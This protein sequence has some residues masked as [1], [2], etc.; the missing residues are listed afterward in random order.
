[1]TEASRTAITTILFTDLVSSTELLQ[2]VGDERAQRI[3]ERHHELLRDAIAAAGGEELQWMGDG[4]MAAFAS[5]ADAVRCAVVMQRAASRGTAGERL[6]IRI[7]L[8]TAET[9]RQDSGSGHFGTPVVVA[10]RLCDV[11]GPGQILCSSV[12]AGLLQGRQ[13]FRFRDVGQRELKGI[14]AP[15]AVCEALYELEHG[16]GVPGRTPFVGRREELERLGQRL[17]VA[18]SGQGGLAMLVGEPGIG[19]TRLLEELAAT[20]RE[21]DTRVLW[22]RCYEGEWAPP[23]GPFAEAIA[24][25]GKR[26]DLEELEK[27]LGPYG[28][29]VAA[30]VPELRE[31]I[32]HLPA[33]PPLQPDEER[34]RLLDAVTQ[35]LLA[36]AQR[37]PVLLMLDDLH[38]ADRGTI[39]MLRHVARFAVQSRIL[40]V[41]AYRD[42]ELD[43][44]HPLADALA[45]LR[46]EVEYQR[47]LLKGLDAGEVAELLGALAA[48]EVPQELAQA[49]DEETDGN[50]F[51]V[52]EVLLHLV[53]E[54]K[55]RREGE[56]FASQLPIEELGIPE[57]VRQVIGRRISRLSAEADRLLSVAS[58]TSGA[59]D[60]E[61][62]AGAAGLEEVTAL[63]ALDE[64]LE[65]QL[66]RPAG[67][68]D[69]YDF[70]HALIRHTLYAELNPSRQVRLH[71]RIAEEME[72]LYADRTAEH[73]GGIAWQY[74]RSAALP[75]AELGVAHCLEAA[76][77]AEGA[78]AHEEAAVFLRMA[79]ELLPEGDPRRPRI[80]ARLGLA[81]AWSL[82]P[83]EA[84]QVASE[85]GEEI[86][87][88]ESPAAA[89]DYLA[90]AAFAVFGAA[91]SPLAWRLA[92]QGLRHIGPRRDL[93]WLRLASL[94][95]A[96]REAED[97]EFPGI[98]LDSPERR[99]LRQVALQHWDALAMDGDSAFGV[100]F[101]SRQEVLS[102]AAESPT[103]LS[104]LA[105]EYRRALPLYEER[106]EAA[107]E[108]GQIAGA[109][110]IRTMIARLQSALGDLDASSASFARAT[111][112]ASRLPRLPFLEWQMS[113][114]P[115]EHV[116]IRGEGFEALVAPIEAT[117][118]ESA[119]ENQWVMAAVRASLAVW[120]AATG[121]TD[122]ALQ[123][124]EAILPAIERAPGWSPNYTVIVCL[125]TETLWTLG[126][127]DHAG[128]IERNLREKTLEPDF[129]YPHQDARRAMAQLCALQGRF[130]EAAEWFAEARRVLEEQGARPLR[131]RVDLDEA[132]MYARRG[133]PGD[134]ERALPLLDAAIA[135]FRPLGMTGYERLASVLR[136][137]LA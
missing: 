59:F 110:M 44:Q 50:P 133:A 112:L 124:L 54:G 131:A 19:K 31:R 29:P 65:A 5:T 49:I 95:L 55:L 13:A 4:L 51:F 72:R 27:D 35:F 85:A 136:R 137:E 1:M 69:L 130:D 41:G 77:R 12:V 104:W 91:M 61:V 128:I 43:R 78:A 89:A 75:G 116:G 99:A 56:G 36:T 134:R 107:I 132:Q 122:D 62:A 98:P 25:Y 14:D 70:T 28:G 26:A 102:H 48:R 68:A 30:L 73:A 40:V 86:A 38:W 52:R 121:R 34:H 88:Q 103:P 118:Q 10:S 96:R 57:G 127:T 64:A 94:D 93:V 18:R 120:Y 109:A 20:A 129:R 6:Q 24:G 87:D 84:V 2:R 45:A 3:L 37:A 92:E 33:P 60:L 71:R 80:L 15:L 42:V 16:A 8:N 126:R 17:E 90:E 23:F 119:S 83:E 11:A 105:G 74:Q 125:A 123:V 21:G 79:L 9:L 46:R 106:E 63:D 22:G 115:L 66:L 97:P 67:G 81:L 53:E 32:P 39:A 108:R 82:E 100:I 111:E 7:G 114:V 101:R 76:A 58:A 135:Q 47:V 113:A 117:R